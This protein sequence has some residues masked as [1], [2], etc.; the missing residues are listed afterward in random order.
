MAA[1]PSD[2]RSPAPPLVLVLVC[3]Q[4]RL[5]VSAATDVACSS[6][7]GGKKFVPRDSAVQYWVE[8]QY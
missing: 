2:C 4:A 6:A 5:S 1:P 8:C 3:V 7:H